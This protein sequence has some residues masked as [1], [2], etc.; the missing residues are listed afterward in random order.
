MSILK[1][2]IIIWFLG[3]TET[4]NR[5]G[6][7]PYSITTD[8]PYLY[9]I[10]EV[11][12]IATHAYVDGRNKNYSANQYYKSNQGIECY[13]IYIGYFNNNFDYILNSKDSFAN[14]VAESFNK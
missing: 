6:Y 4:A 5:N 2:I 1:I 9:T 3:V 13:Q 7:E 11:G 14:A 12:G 8:T 10:R